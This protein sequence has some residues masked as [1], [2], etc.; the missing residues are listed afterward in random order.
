M[1]EIVKNLKELT[2]KHEIQLSQIREKLRLLDTIPKAKALEGKCFKYRNGYTFGGKRQ[3]WC[4]K[5]IFA[6]VG[7][8][9]LVDTFQTEGNSKIEFSFNEI[10]HVMR[11][12]HPSYIPISRN[13]YFKQLN[14]H[15][16]ML[17]KRG[18]YG[19]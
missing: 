14:R 3:G 2:N 1:D 19:K 17:R 11:F 13:T 7:E 9:L 8:N 6:V 12:A 15:L 10:E 18:L 5:R 4:Y 16:K